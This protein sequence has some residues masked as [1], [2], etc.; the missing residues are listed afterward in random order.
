MWISRRAYT[1]LLA[2]TQQTENDAK[3]TIDSIKSEVALAIQDAEA[4][5]AK[6]EAESA[7]LVVK[8][9][10]RAAFAE[11]A[12]QVER[13]ENSRAQRHWASM[14]LRREKSFPLPPT[15]EEK[16]EARDKAAEERDRPPILTDVQLAMRDA[17]RREA[18]KFGKTW[19]E[20]DADFEREFLNQMMETE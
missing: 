18:A 15:A 20:A 2:Q 4:L 6:R 10:S 14:F 19:E 16:E 3:A 17:N 7:A 8:A 9:E 11:S 13:R 1:S 5:V 12:L